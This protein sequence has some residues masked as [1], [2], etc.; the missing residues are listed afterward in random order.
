MTNI[1]YSICWWFVPSDLIDTRRLQTNALKGARD[2][3]E[4]AEQIF[5][6]LFEC[7]GFVTG[8]A[9]SAMVAKAKI[10]FSAV[11]A[12]ARVVR[13][14]GHGFFFSKP[15]RLFSSYTCTFLCLGYHWF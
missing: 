10:V 13:T 4:I 9:C 5:D 2:A 7:G 14:N 12:A 11:L 8:D 15:K 6:A 3:L 1:F